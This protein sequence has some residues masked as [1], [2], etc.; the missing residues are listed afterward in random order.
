[1]MEHCVFWMTAVRLPVSVHILNPCLEGGWQKRGR[2]GGKWHHPLF[3]AFKG[4]RVDHQGQTLM[5]VC[6]W[7]GFGGCR[8]PFNATFSGVGWCG[9][10]CVVLLKE[11]QEWVAHWGFITRGVTQINDP[12]PC[13]IHAAL[14][15]RWVNNLLHIFHVHLL[16]LSQG[17]PS[18]FYIFGP[19][20][21]WFMYRSGELCSLISQ[22]FTA[23]S[24]ICRSFLKQK[25]K[26]VNDSGSPNC[27][28][29]RVLSACLTGSHKIK[30]K[31]S[32]DTQ[33]HSTESQG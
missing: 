25:G 20:G 17:E 11:P 31:K 14:R 32:H 24:H 27:F 22:P 21:N 28:I 19:V 18:Y 5:N 15:F 10:V 12:L 6:Q 1:M 23:W 29:I 13:S 9:K 4:W 30:K 3:S 16:W 26:I 33:N 7:G 8:T 2:H